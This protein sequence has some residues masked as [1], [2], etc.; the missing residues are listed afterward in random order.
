MDEQ[1]N[2][3][4]VTFGSI[5]DFWIDRQLNTWMEYQFPD[6]FQ[7]FTDF[8]V[9]GP[10]SP[11]YGETWTNNGQKIKPFHLDISQN[12]GERKISSKLFNRILLIMET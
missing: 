3:F 10:M 7:I 8:L 6:R 2:A 12:S 11:I 5:V 9:R 4:I 1:S